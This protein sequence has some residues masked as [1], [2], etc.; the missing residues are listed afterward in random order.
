ME[1]RILETLLQD[2][3]GRDCA[4]LGLRRWN[5][6]HSSVAPPAWVASG[7]LWFKE[8]NSLSTERALS[9][10]IHCVVHSGTLSNCQVSP[11]KSAVMVNCSVSPAFVCTQLPAGVNPADRF[12]QSALQAMGM[13]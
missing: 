5:E 3:G 12:V 9:A 2:M 8:E 10:L 7:C 11:L 1:V 6:T 4:P 13:A